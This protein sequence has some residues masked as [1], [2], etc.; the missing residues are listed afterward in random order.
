[1]T[2]PHSPPQDDASPHPVRHRRTAILV[3]TASL[4]VAIGA[5]FY[6]VNRPKDYIVIPTVNDTPHIID[7]S[8]MTSYVFINKY[9]KI[10]ITAQNLSLPV[11]I[12]CHLNNFAVRLGIINWFRRNFLDLCRDNI[13]INNSGKIKLLGNAL[14]DK[15]FREYIVSLKALWGDDVPFMIFADENLIFR[16]TAHVLKILQE[17]G[18]EN[19]RIAAQSEDHQLLVHFRVFIS[20]IDPGRSPFIITVD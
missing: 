10:K 1:M 6:Y 13:L 14:S 18:V 5:F 12:R 15:E 2:E 11:S 17:E 19:I 8:P 16:D 3:L 4:L 20:D 7:I 9:G